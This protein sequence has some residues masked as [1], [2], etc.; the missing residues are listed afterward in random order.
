MDTLTPTFVGAFQF[1]FAMQIRRRVMWITFFFFAVF[2]YALAGQGN[3][4]HWQG[5]RSAADS[6]ADWTVVVNLL[7]PIAVGVLLADRLRR[8]KNT[9]VDELLYT[10]P[11]S[12]GGRLLGKYL[13]SVLA[14]LVPFF[15]VYLGGVAFITYHWVPMQGLAQVLAQWPIALALFLAVVVPGS[16]FVAGFSIAL[17]LVIWVPLYQLLFVC[18]WFWGNALEPGRGIPTLSNTILTPLGAYMLAGFFGVDS[19]MVVHKATALQGLASLTLLIAL[20]ICAM[21]AIW[22]YIRWVISQ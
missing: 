10:L 12:L 17:P 14:T 20:G 19:G 21:L 5:N 1:E 18:Y 15:L 7:L 2:V 6:F 16:L 3:W 9:R 4:S 8:D 22:Q 13:G 11:G